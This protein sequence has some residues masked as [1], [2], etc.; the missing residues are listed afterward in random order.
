ML[1]YL[2]RPLPSHIEPMAVLMRV[3]VHAQ[4]VVAEGTFPLDPASWHKTE[5]SETIAHICGPSRSDQYDEGGY[6][7]YGPTTISHLTHSG[8]FALTCDTSSPLSSMCGSCM[9]HVNAATT[10]TLPDGGACGVKGDSGSPVVVNYTAL[11][12]ATEIP[13]LPPGQPYVVG[14]SS[15]GSDTADCAGGPGVARYTGTWD[16]RYVT[17][18]NE[19]RATN[20]GTFILTGLRDFD[21]DGVPNEQDNCPVAP[22]PDQ[23]NCNRDAEQRHQFWNAVDSSGGWRQ[24]NE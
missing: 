14:V 1:L 13:I 7:V 18:D 23:A 6:R 3:G 24:G 10:D 15:V 5:T 22:N 11:P 17:P 20:N 8:A 12:P 21:R 16:S 9:V 4:Q 19:L 2:E